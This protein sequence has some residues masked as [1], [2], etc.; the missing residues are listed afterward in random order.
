MMVSISH[1]GRV[2]ETVLQFKKKKFKWP[3]PGGSDSKDPACN[4]GDRDLI[5]R[6]G[7]S[8]GEGN[9]NLLLPGE[10][11]WTEEPGGLQS[12]GLPRVRHN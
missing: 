11:P 9:D 12:T 4:A 8:P 1:R 3:F 2:Q 6:L 7:R 10:S 5:P